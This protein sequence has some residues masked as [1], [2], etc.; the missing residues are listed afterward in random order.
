MYLQSEKD[1]PIKDIIVDVCPAKKGRVQLWDGC[2]NG[3]RK[4]PGLQTTSGQPKA[5]QKAGTKRHIVMLDWYSPR[6]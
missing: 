4:K 2:L 6:I 1:A 3:W 5:L